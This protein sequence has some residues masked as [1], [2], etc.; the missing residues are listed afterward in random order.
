MVL[1]LGN[2]K[3][4]PGKQPEEFT[5]STEGNDAAF[6][7]LPCFTFVFS[8]DLLLETCCGFINIVVEK[9]VPCFQGISKIT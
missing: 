4:P 8:F 3:Y 7:G 2:S 9:V 6:L 5:P 1:V